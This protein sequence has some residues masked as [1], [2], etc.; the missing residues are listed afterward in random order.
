MNVIMVIIETPIFTKLIKETMTDDE[1]R[2]LQEALIVNP[3]LGDTIKHSG[4]LRKIRWSQNTQ[5]KRGGARVIYYWKND[6][7]QI[8]M[9]FVFTKKTQADL[10]ANQLKAL[11]KIVQEW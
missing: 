2:R 8:Y 5:G 9:I 11:R 6:L 3:Y 4:G 1:Y 7:E 10:S